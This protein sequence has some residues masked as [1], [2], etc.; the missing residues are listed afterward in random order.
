MP[1]EVNT[2]QTIELLASHRTLGK[3]PREELAWLAEHGT[4]VHYQKGDLIARQG[5]RADGLLVV[6]SGRFAVYLNR[7]TGM[8]RTIESGTGDVAGLLPF[9]R[10]AGSPGEVY[11]EEPSKVLLIPSDLM[12]ELI[13]NCYEVTAILVH[14]MIDRARRFTSA[15]LRDEKMISLGKLAA[16]FAHEVN[17]PASA[18]LRGASALASTLS[19]ADEAARALYTSGLTASQL[20]GLDALWTGTK[21]TTAHAPMSGLE[22]ADREDAI[23]EWLTRHD[24]ADTQ[25][26]ELAGS[27]ITVTDLDN[28]AASFSSEKL[29]VA[30]RWLTA[31]ASAR[32]LVADIE[33]ATKRIH[34]L[35]AAAKGFTHMDRTPEVESVEVSAGIQETAMLLDGK[36][37]AKSV[38][39][40]LNILQDLPSIRGYA[41]EINQI[42]MNLIDNAI[43][44]APN[45]G[46]VFVS[47]AVDGTDVIVSV[48]DDGPGI[49]PEIREQI[50]DPFFTTK[51]VGEG[52]GLGL[53]IV[54]RVVNWHNGSVMVSSQPGKTEFKVRM[55]IGK[56]G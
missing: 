18:A 9:S 34:A 27:S 19:M 7:G 11:A 33:R 14:A 30:I 39:I 8:R 2:D 48:S 44:A 28:L 6:F 4:L 13:R 49:P 47:A 1:T 40:A 21:S 5:D 17:N 55:P 32:S 45:G 37:R 22:L 29:E 56:A 36:A 16:G 26:G 51:A 3:A 53:D 23:E 24:I 43:D 41:A 12:P 35:V 10:M 54:R 25:A 15:D 50:F 38:A 31:T 42:W 20:T 46:H 52:T